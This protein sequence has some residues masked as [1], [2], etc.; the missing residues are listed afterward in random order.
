MVR[1]F[2]LLGLLTSGLFV[3]VALFF[4]VQTAVAAPASQLPVVED[5]AI[6]ALQWERFNDRGEVETIRYFT[7]VGGERRLLLTVAG[8]T[9]EDR[10]LTSRESQAYGRFIAEATRESL[11]TVLADIFGA[12]GIV[13]TPAQIER[14][15]KARGR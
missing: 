12:R 13:L 9:R 1:R 8:L 11:G 4:V 2:F 15:D 7:A 14:I 5:T 6:P 3:G 10:P